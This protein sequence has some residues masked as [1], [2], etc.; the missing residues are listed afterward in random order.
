MSMRSEDMALVRLCRVHG[1]KKKNILLSTYEGEHQTSGGQVQGL[2][3][4][5]RRC[6]C[7]RSRRPDRNQVTPTHLQGKVN[8]DQ[9][10]SRAET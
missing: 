7:L 9:K 8:A 6:R 10:G 4:K 2:E 3:V 5:T 1:D